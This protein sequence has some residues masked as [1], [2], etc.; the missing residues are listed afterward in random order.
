MER[1]QEKL[2]QCIMLKDNYRLSRL[3]MDVALDVS[4]VG[5]FP[6][7]TAATQARLHQ[8]KRQKDEG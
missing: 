7:D 8:D 3:L 6:L 2:R 1:V 4:Y 5:I